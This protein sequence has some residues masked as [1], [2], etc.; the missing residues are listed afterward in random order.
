VTVTIISASAGSG[1]THRLAEALEQALTREKYPVAPEAVL[2][3]TF[4]NKAAAE[5]QERARRHLLMHGRV[6]DAQRLAAARFGTVNSVCGRLVAD[7]AFELGLPPDQRVLEEGAAQIALHR[8][9]STVRTMEESL[10]IKELEGRFPFFRVRTAVERVIGLARAN[11]IEPESFPTCAERSKCEVRELLDKAVEDGG[12]LDGALRAALADFDEALARGIDPTAGATT[13]GQRVSK[14]LARLHRGLQ[15]SWDEWAAL[16][17]LKTTKKSKHL[18]ERIHEAAQR[19]LAHPRFH[20]DLDRLID[21]V[22][23]LARRGLVA[24]AEHKRA[25]GTVDFVDQEALAYRLLE[26]EDVRE[27]LRGELRLV[28]VD[29]FQDT[30]PLQLA[31]FL[32]LAELS[33]ESLWVGDQKQSIFGFRGA[34][35]ELMEAAIDGLLGGKAPE[36]LATSYR[37]RAALV[38]C[39]SDLFARAF[40]RHGLAEERVRLQPAPQ[41]LME[42]QEL[43]SIAERWRLTAGNQA[44]DPLALAAAVRDFLADEAVRVREPMTGEVR[45]PEAKD[46]AILCRRNACSRAVAAALADLGIRA[47][48]PRM[49]LLATPEGQL[50]LAGLRLWSD[51]GD[52]RAAAAI[53]RLGE[54]PADGAEWLETALS[55]PRAEGFLAGERVHRLLAARAAAPSAGPLL[56]LD[57]VLAALDARGLCAD[58]GSTPLRLANL[59]ALR[60]HAEVFAERHAADGAGA[61]PA[62]FVGDL[63]N[64]FEAELDSQATVEAQDAVTLSTWHLAKGREWPIVVLFELEPERDPSVFDVAVERDDPAFDFR[65]PLAGRWLRL[66]PTIFQASRSHTL[67]HER[68]ADH[69]VACA[70]QA[71]QDREMLRL[72]YVGWT[73]ARDRVIIAARPTKLLNGILRHLAAVDGT[74]L[75]DDPEDGA[76]RWAGRRVEVKQRWAAPLPPAPRDEH[77]GQTYVA[78]GFRMYPAAWQQP[79]ASGATGEL[80]TV[81]RLGER[82]ELRGRWDERSLGEAMHRFFAADLPE[83][84]PGDR[85]R[86]AQGLLDRWKLADTLAAEELLKAGD[87][88]RNWVERRWPVAKW[89][90]EWPVARRVENGSVMRGAVDLVLESDA[91]YV[92]VDHKTFPGGIEPALERTRGHGG[93]LRSYAGMLANATGAQ[94]LECYVHLPVGG[95]VVEVKA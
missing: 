91:G 83:L 16:A 84:E 14:D 79:S 70:A 90:R 58:W 65:S 41:V 26:R 57:T 62:S 85:F 11:G 3:T 40:A 49:G 4:T 20:E 93:Q 51:P 60:G 53:A 39:T 33:P 73:R 6:E 75:L 24:Y 15:L 35:A 23:N 34:D 25:T 50:A 42:L 94:V 29:E 1:K 19:F 38:N 92:I 18:A 72:L 55:A 61:T 88:L 45:R 64:L 80:G 22:F 87:R 67:V 12:N 76:C 78:A 47:V 59:D 9:L 17:G 37:S 36:T 32:R 48:L 82:L 7:F 86:M 2:A 27:R 81:E 56:A 54:F 13:A 31:I 69:R 46:I 89:R 28:L 95:V 74:S 71:R 66:W 44:E 43:G 8:A 21:I 30:S 5:L 63:E 68:L 10:T 52:H 77:P